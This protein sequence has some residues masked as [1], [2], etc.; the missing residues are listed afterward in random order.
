MSVVSTTI[1]AAAGEKARAGARAARTGSGDAS[2]RERFERAYERHAG[3]LLAYLSK[4][5]SDRAFVEDVSAETFLR[6]LDRYD[7]PLDDVARTRAW[8]LRV[9]TNEAN[10]WMRRKH[11]RRRAL[12][13]LAGSAGGSG[14]SQ[15]ESAP[16][17]LAKL[18]IESLPLHEQEA[19]TLHHGCGLSVEQIAGVLGVAQGT[20]RARLS[21]GRRRALAIAERLGL[22]VGA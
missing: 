8:I 3:E 17:S 18:L 1:R 4:R 7:G 20:V 16:A 19:L 13:L 2:E 14:A 10:R 11:V 6:L 5:Y 9:A 22:E 21:R 12:R 15:A